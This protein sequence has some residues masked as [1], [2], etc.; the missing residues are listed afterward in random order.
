[1]LSDEELLK[2][3]PS[4]VEKATYISDGLEGTDKVDVINFN[5]M[6]REIAPVRMTG[7]YGSQVLKGIFGFDARPPYMNVI[8]EEFKK[9]VDMAKETASELQKGHKLTF[10]LQSADSL[11]VECLC[12]A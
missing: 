6:A 8:Q 5:R 3:Y 9:Y 2:E 11:V 7:K 1:M 4:E 12:Y 10:L